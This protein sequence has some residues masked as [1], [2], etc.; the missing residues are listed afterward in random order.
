VPWQSPF[1]QSPCGQRRS[2]EEGLEHGPS[3]PAIPHLKN[4]PFKSKVLCFDAD[5]QIIDTQ[6][7]Y[8]M[9]AF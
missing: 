8:K 4:E 6:N 2:G 7:V 3:G 1:G 5:I 9:S